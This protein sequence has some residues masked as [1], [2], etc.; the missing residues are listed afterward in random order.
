[1]LAHRPVRVLQARAEAVGIVSIHPLAYTAHCLD[2]GSSHVSVF[3]FTQRRYNAEGVRFADTSS[4]LAL[5]QVCQRI[6]GDNLQL[7]FRAKV[8][9]RVRC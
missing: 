1:M 3:V 4:C 7:L 8:R 9:Q 2:S 5:T 6:Q